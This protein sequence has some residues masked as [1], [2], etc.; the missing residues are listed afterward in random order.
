MNNNSKSQLKIKKVLFLFN[1]FSLIQGNFMYIT[2][3]LFI[4]N[5]YLI[6]YA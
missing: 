4:K 5:L 6:T 3:I 2:I 1:F